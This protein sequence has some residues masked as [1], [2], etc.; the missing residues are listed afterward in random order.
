VVR[1]FTMNGRWKPE[2][3]PLSAAAAEHK[4]IPTPLARF[5][6]KPGQTGNPG[7]RTKAFAEA[8]RICREASPE[9][10]R[11]M[12][13]LIRS[14]DERVALMAADKVYERAWGKPKEYDPSTERDPS[15]SRFDPSLLSPE[16]LDLVEHALRLIV[17]ATRAPSPVTDIEDEG[18]NQVRA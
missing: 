5:A 1:T 7:G 11:R 9:A 13:E 3:G 6:F 14:E 18:H 15:R 10:A 16:Q 4:M 2:S 17:K 12:V 8:Q